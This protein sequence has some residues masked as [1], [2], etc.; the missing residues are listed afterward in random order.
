MREKAA[1]IG[2]DRFG[3]AGGED[4]GRGLLGLLGRGANSRDGAGAI[5]G[6]G[7]RGDGL[8]AADFL[9]LLLLEH[10]QQSGILLLHAR[11]ARGRVDDPSQ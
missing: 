3:Q 2:E 7:R 10:G 5:C 9:I 8:E 11:E 1:G 4:S 6:A